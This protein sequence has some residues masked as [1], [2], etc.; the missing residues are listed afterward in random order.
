[1]A[2][3]IGDAKDINVVL[4]WAM[5]L[6]VH[7]P[8][9][10]PLT[11]EQATEAGKRLAGKAYRALYAG[12]MPEHVT[13]TRDELAGDPACRVCGCTENRPC[14]GG[15]RWVEDPAMLGEL[16]DRCLPVLEKA[17]LLPCAG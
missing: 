11:D 4:H 17:G 15:C 5:G 16:C 10:P 8:G 12:I 9:G 13:L 1:M 14:Q 2:L 6:D 3:T 7:W